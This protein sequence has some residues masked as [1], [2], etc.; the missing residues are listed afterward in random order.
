M[1]DLKEEWGEKSIISPHL[2]LIP[3]CIKSEIKWIIL[4]KIKK[5]SKSKVGSEKGI[6]NP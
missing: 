4:Y 6:K 2:F 3:E 1:V 5:M